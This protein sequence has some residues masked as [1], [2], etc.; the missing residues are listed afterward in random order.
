MTVH[1]AASIEKSKDSF[2]GGK[3]FLR[4]KIRQ[5]IRVENNIPYLSSIN[6]YENTSFL[7]ADL[8]FDAHLC[9]VEN[10]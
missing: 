1:V 9:M 5:T 3:N 7:S 6:W 4:V 2:I 8:S 10:T